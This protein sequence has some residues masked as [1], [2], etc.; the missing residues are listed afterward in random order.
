MARPVLVVG[1]AAR[2][3]CGADTKT[4]KRLFLP[5]F[6]RRYLPPVALLAAE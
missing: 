5:A 6:G 3:T 4:K 1:M 2:N